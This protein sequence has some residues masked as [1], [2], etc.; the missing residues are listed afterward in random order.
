MGDLRVLRPLLRTRL[1]RAPKD[2]PGTVR[3]NPHINPGVIS[4]PS[5]VGN[6]NQLIRFV[7]GDRVPIEE[8]STGGSAVPA[9]GEKR[10]HAL[11]RTP[12]VEQTIASTER[13]C[14]QS[15]RACNQPWPAKLSP[16]R[17]KAPAISVSP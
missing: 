13:V 10:S 4:V 12:G 2:F 17:I 14:S 11:S 15:I 9:A 7:S 5:W 1:F 8:I 3:L 6:N 16:P